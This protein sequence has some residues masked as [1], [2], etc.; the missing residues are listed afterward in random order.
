MAEPS[1][2][3]PESELVVNNLA[4]ALTA[5]PDANWPKE[6]AD[7]YAIRSARAMLKLATARN[8][9]INLAGAMDALVQAT[10]DKRDEIKIVACKILAYL[11]S[12]DAQRAIAD[13]ALKQENSVDI[14]MSSFESLAVSAK[15]NAN[16]LLDTQIDQI[17]QIVASRETA[18]DL[19]SSAAAAFGALN[20]PS[21]RVKYLIM[22]QTKI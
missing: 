20:L 3:F 19:R 10:G 22:E 1:E 6:T 13:A 11:P 7:N 16:Q 12:P 15:V 5:Q 17:Y 14:R 9:V 4:S 18:Q 21:R 8:S 2:K